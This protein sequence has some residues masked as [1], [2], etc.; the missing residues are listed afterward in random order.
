MHGSIQQRQQPSPEQ[1]RQKAEE[2]KQ[3]APQSSSG[4]L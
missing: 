4:D 2:E 1:P 3:E